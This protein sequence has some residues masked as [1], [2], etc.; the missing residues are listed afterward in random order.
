MAGKD[1]QY[2]MKNRLKKLQDREAHRVKINEEE[3]SKNTA[4]GGQS[5]R[6]THR[7]LNFENEEEDEQARIDRAL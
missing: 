4:R 3:F 1:D 7:G 5:G 2:S 6:K